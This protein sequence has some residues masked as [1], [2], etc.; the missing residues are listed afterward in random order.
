MNV[1]M[2]V[3]ASSHEPELCDEQSKGAGLSSSQLMS[4][5]GTEQ[6]GALPDVHLFLLR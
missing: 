1:V 3:A 6:P 2:T 4:G 5:T